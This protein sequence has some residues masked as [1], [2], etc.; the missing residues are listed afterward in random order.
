MLDL[1]KLW[2]DRRKTVLFVTHSIAEAVFLSDRVVVLTPRPARIR[3]I[4]TVALPRP[5]R[6]SIQQT[7]EFVGYAEQIRQ[8]FQA[9]GVLRD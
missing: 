5:R 2:Q 6:L 1:L 8:I 7:P 9:E 4:I 3:E